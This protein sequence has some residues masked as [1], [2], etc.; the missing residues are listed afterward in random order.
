M[1]NLSVPWDVVNQKETKSSHSK[2]DGFKLMLWKS[3][4]KAL[5][6]CTQKLSQN[7]SACIFATV[8]SENGE[9]TVNKIHP[10]HSLNTPKNLQK[11]KVKVLQQC[12]VFCSKGNEK[13]S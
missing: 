11:T 6:S 5:K 12:T 8:A 3:Y 2:A 9:M 1:A 10:A 13:T 4:S 7:R